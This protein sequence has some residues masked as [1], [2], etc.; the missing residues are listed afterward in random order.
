MASWQTW[1]QHTESSE[2]GT[3]M[4]M[5]IS[6]AAPRSAANVLIGPNCLQRWCKCTVGLGNTIRSQHR[7]QRNQN[8]AMEELSDAL[9]YLCYRGHGVA[10]ILQSTENI[11][12]L[13]NEAIS[14]PCPAAL[15]WAPGSTQEYRASALHT[16]T[17]VKAP[18]SREQL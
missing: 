5:V 6:K 8:H 13:T 10:S 15:P 7:G 4:N 14:I 17:P 18:C 16:A 2:Y 3:H 9:I 11:Q 1:P 12:A